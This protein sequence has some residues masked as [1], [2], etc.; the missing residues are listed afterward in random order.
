[1]ENETFQTTETSTELMDLL[2]NIDFTSMETGA[3][4]AIVANTKAKL[5]TLSIE[6]KELE[7]KDTANFK[8][9][10]RLARTLLKSGVSTTA[11]L[12][13]LNKQFGRAPEVAGEQTRKSH[14]LSNDAPNEILAFVAAH[15]EGVSAQQIW[16]QFAMMD[17]TGISI[18]VKQLVYEGK[19]SG[20]GNT[21]QRKYF[22]VG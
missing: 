4:R 13:V 7:A 8:V 12:E 15:Q 22:P 10:R 5:A 18:V 21:R 14:K 20:V 17:K 2:S 6:L 19:I 3:M 16:N 9:A 1:M 11:A